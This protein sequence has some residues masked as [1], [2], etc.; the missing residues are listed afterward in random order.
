M[1][2]FLRIA[3][4]RFPAPPRDLMRLEA[5][6]EPVPGLK[7]EHLRGRG[8]FAE[9]WEAVDKKGNRCAVKFMTARNS[10]SSVKETRIIQAIRKLYHKNL[11]RVHDVFSIP[12]YIVVAMELADGSLLDLLDVWQAEYK[13]SL[14]PDLIVGYLRQAASALDFLNARRHPFEGKVVGF[15]H[16]DVKPSNLLLIGETVKLADFGLCVPVIAQQSHCS[17]A[18]TLDFAAPEVHGHRL[19]DTS[20]QYSLAISYHYLRT[21]TFPFPEQPGFDRGYSYSRPAPD[22]SRVRRGERRVLERALEL[23][24]SNRWPTCSAFIAALAEALKRADPEPSPSSGELRRP[25]VTP[26]HPAPARP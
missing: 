16:C 6:T 23:E 12:E 3:P 21:G 7:L 17:R 24:P 18:G 26:P 25:V 11:V 8:G 22:L 2:Q 14:S 4:A 20:D 5:G 15:Q 13:T 9:V 10:S 1:L 19:A